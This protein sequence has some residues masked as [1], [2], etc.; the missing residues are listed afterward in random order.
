MVSYLLDC[1][2]LLQLNVV[3][4][5]RHFQVN[6]SLVLTRITISLTVCSFIMG[7]A[8]DPFF[9]A[10]PP[11]G[12]AAQQSR[13]HICSEGQSVQGAAEGLAGLHWGRPAASQED[14]R[15]V[16]PT[17]THVH[18]HIVTSHNTHSV[19]P[20]NKLLSPDSTGNPTKLGTFKY[21]YL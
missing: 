2:E 13:Q 19:W 20:A 1:F 9:V 4:T 17:W 5:F 6:Y 12:R 7:L 3:L 10:A 14:P 15:Q 21:M 11:A 16:T 8:D 18:W